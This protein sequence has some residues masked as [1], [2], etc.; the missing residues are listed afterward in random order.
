MPLLSSKPKYMKAA[1]LWKIGR[2]LK[3][4]NKIQNPNLKLRGMEKIIDKYLSEDKLEV[5]LRIVQA[6][7]DEDLRSESMEKIVDK[8][9][10]E[11]K[12]DKLLIAVAADKGDA[13]SQTEW[14]EK[15]IDKCLREKKIENLR[16][17]VMD[18]ES[19]K[20]IDE[21]L[22][23]EWMEKIDSACTAKVDSLIQ[24]GKL[25]EALRIVNE[26]QNPILKYKG[27]KNI[28]IACTHCG[29][30]DPRKLQNLINDHNLNTAFIIVVENDLELLEAKQPSW[31]W[32]PQ[33]MKDIV[34]KCLSENKLKNLFITAKAI[35]NADMRSKW[36]KQIIDECLSQNKL[37]DALKAANN[38][39][40]AEI[41]RALTEKVDSLIKD[42][43]LIKSKRKSLNLNFFLKFERVSHPRTITFSSLGVK[44]L[45]EGVCVKQSSSYAIKSLDC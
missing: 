26:I 45:M 5:L 40:D 1:V 7:D 44:S 29:F 36:M 25:D 31:K 32:G 21:D 33:W 2:K 24:A 11:N 16:E 20:A 12:L 13:I 37:D 42:D 10:S 14:I 3:I 6:I 8:C 4:V 15:I 38:I 9:L 17:S 18:I 19:K 43:K 35:D 23:S 41:D 22:R 28:K 27:M 34:A 30:I 39:K